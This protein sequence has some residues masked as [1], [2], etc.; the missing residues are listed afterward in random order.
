VERI[1][2]NWTA[3]MEAYRMQFS[4]DCPLLTY[5]DKLEEFY[6]ILHACSQV[7][8][9]SQ[10]TSAPSG[11]A[12]YWALIEL[13]LHALNIDGPLTIIDPTTERP[14]EDMEVDEER[15]AAYSIMIVLRLVLS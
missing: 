7:I 10:T 14:Y 9:V 5:R 13:R 3:V 4:K 1:L 15:C 11:A 12:G 8:K 2:K 6:S